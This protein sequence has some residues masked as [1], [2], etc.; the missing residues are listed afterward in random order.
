MISISHEVLL[1][2]LA[3][4]PDLEIVDFYWTSEFPAGS[5]HVEFH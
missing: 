2:A 4:V 1:Q 3:I 5:S